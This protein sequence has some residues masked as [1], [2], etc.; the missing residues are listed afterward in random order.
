MFGLDAFQVAA[1]SPRYTM[2]DQNSRSKA[3]QQRSFSHVN[4]RSVDS[5][6]ELSFETPRIHNVSI[7][8]THEYMHSD[9]HRMTLTYR[10]T[11]LNS[12]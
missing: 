10:H 11:P 8:D 12:K 7:P 5:L 3:A 4:V 2:C 9:L 1:E 6:A